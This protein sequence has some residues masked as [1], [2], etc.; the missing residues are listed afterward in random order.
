MTFEE[1]FDAW[2]TTKDPEVR[3]LC[4]IAWHTGAYFRGIWTPPVETD[5]E[6][7]NEKKSG[8]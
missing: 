5:E 4:K 6:E 1:W 8:S 2:D 3:R 7:Q